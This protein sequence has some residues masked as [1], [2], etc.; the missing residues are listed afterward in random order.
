MPLNTNSYKTYV[1][2]PS[3]CVGQKLQLKLDVVVIILLDV[4]SGICK[5]HTNYNNKSLTNDNLWPNF[6]NEF[7]ISGQINVTFLS[8]PFKYPKMSKISQNTTFMSVKKIRKQLDVEVVCYPCS[9]FDAVRDSTCNIMFK[10]CYYHIL[11]ITVGEQFFVRNLTGPISSIW[12]ECSMHAAAHTHHLLSEKVPA[13]YWAQTPS[14]FLSSPQQRKGGPTRLTLP[15]KSTVRL[16]W[17]LLHAERALTFSVLANNYKTTYRIL[18]FTISML[19]FFFPNRMRTWPACWVQVL[20]GTWR[21]SAWPSPMSPVPVPSSLSSC[22]H[23]N[24]ST[25]GPHRY[26]HTRTQH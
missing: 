7:V 5:N 4:C 9:W 14:F 10:T 15:S 18:A 21:T 1:S 16:H 19:N 20:L 2:C 13:R 23:S 25:S 22:L 3:V 6:F 24:S 11:K 8:E 26:T 12:H 17:S